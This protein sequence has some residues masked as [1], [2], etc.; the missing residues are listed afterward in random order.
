MKKYYTY[1]LENLDEI[2]YIGST[3][4]LELRVKNHNDSSQRGWTKKR[5]P[6]KLIYF[7][8]FSTRS[9]AVVRE[10]FLKKLK[11]GK[12][13]KEILKISRNS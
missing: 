11:A 5:G 12:R 8:E 1:L 13:I 6:W 4:N 9:E 7:E 3:S 10:K 2:I